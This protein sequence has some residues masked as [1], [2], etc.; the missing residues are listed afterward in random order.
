M[1]DD[2]SKRSL[3][4]HIS[5]LELAYSRTDTNFIH[6]TALLSFATLV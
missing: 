6:Q 4:R 2:K 3:I 5:K 1:V